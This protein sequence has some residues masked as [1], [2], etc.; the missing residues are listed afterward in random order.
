MVD[1]YRVGNVIVSNEM[2]DDKMTLPLSNIISGQEQ[3][4][5]NYSND[6]AKSFLAH[7]P[8][9]LK[10]AGDIIYYPRRGLT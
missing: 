4:F 9:V 8:H 1:R 10:Y 7:I 6:K 5:V 3:K 2:N